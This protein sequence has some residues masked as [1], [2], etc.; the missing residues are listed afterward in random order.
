MVDAPSE[1]VVVVDDRGRR[2]VSWSMQV[3]DGPVTFTHDFPDAVRHHYEAGD[4]GEDLLLY[5]GVFS[6]DDDDGYVGDVRWR[7]GRR[8]YIEVRGHRPTTLNDLRELFDSTEGM[9]VQPSTLGIELLD[10][11]L[12]A[13]PASL[14]HAEPEMDPPVRPVSS[15]SLS[16]RV[17]QE[18]GTASA[19]HHVPSWCPTDGRASTARGSAT[20]RT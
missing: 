9:W 5:A 14:P 13:Q 1:P 6:V 4:P 7:W 10:G 15:R 16:R 19:L 8:P 17:E 3:E 20:R 2:T 18:L 11:V 12:P